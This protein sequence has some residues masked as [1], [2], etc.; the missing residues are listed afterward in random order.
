M[1]IHLT[2]ST[3]SL[4]S[5][6]ACREHSYLST[7]LGMWQ[8]HRLK[9]V[10]GFLSLDMTAGGTS[11]TSQKFRPHNRAV[12]KRVSTEVLTCITSCR[13]TSVVIFCVAEPPKFSARAAT[14]AGLVIGSPGCPSGAPVRGLLR[15]A[16][17]SRVRLVPSASVGLHVCTQCQNP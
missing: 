15:P 13:H 9:H 12:L 7:L 6:E 5:P 4:F 10:G 2:T 1:K 17:N 3:Q 14:V 8:N 16:Q 11:L